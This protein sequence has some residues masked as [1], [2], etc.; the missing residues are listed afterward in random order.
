MN[1]TFDICIYDWCTEVSLFQYLRYYC[2][3]MI[4]SPLFAITIIYYNC[5][6]SHQTCNKIVES[7][8]TSLCLMTP[9]SIWSSSVRSASL[10]TDKFLDLVKGRRRQISRKCLMGW[11][12]GMELLEETLVYPYIWSCVTSEGVSWKCWSWKSPVAFRKQW[13]RIM[14]YTMISHYILNEASHVFRIPK[15]FSSSFRTLWG[16]IRSSRFSRAFLPFP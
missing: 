3:I 13:S 15:L 11:M 7:Q 8:S 2:I 4:S 9:A 10:K 12:F 1:L 14:V 6:L 5:T 16:V